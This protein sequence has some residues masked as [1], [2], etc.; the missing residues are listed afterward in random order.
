[1]EGLKDEILD[2]GERLKWILEEI[3]YMVEL[4][5]KNVFI[6]LMLLDP[7]DEYKL[8]IHKGDFL[9][10]DPVKEFGIEEFDLICSNPPYQTS[11]KDLR[12]SKSLY[13]LF[14]DNS[15]KISNKVIMITP[16]RWFSNIDLKQFRYDMINNYGLKIIKNFKNSEEIFNGIE[17]KGGVSYFLLDKNYNGEVLINSD[18]RNFKKYNIISDMD[19]DSILDKI[20][21]F[22]NITYNFNS[23]SYFKI[24]TNDERLCDNSKKIKCYVSKQ[25]GCV[26][27]IDDDSIKKKENFK[28]YKV[29]IPSASGDK[30]NIGKLGNIIIAKPGEVC[31]ASFVHFVFETEEEC[32][33]FK[34]YISTKL[35]KF[36]IGLRKPTQRVKKD[37]FEW[38]P[39]LDVNKEWNDKKINDY[40]NLSLSEIDF[41]QK[42]IF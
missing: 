10:F 39:L 13:N 36:L 15:I 31:S 8:N 33:N 32:L 4:Q 20:S 38:V 1:M 28:K 40:F 26:R 3:I 23:G 14:I 25:K 7:N 30:N 37:I 2:E 42:N 24:E 34:N 41:L 11:S 35:I 19:I 12:G 18:Y 29:L 6:L 16:S 5:P 27:Y 17:L 21:N 9:Q 22:K